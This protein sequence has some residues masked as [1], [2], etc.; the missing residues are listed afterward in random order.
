MQLRPWLNANAII[1]VCMCSYLRT[2]FNCVFHNS[3]VVLVNFYIK[4]LSLIT[5]IHIHFQG[6]KLSNRNISNYPIYTLV[7]LTT[8]YEIII[9]I[10]VINM[11]NDKIN[12][13]KAVEEGNALNGRIHLTKMGGGVVGTDAPTSLNSDCLNT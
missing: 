1:I 11:S 5:T 12:F 6:D 4:L 3:N 8:K 10:I 2:C 13:N 7:S 9:I